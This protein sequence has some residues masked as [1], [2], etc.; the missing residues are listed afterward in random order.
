MEESRLKSQQ[1]EFRL[2]L[3]MA[4]VS[5]PDFEASDTSSCKNRLH[6]ISVRN[7]LTTI[8]LS[9]RRRD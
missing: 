9:G 6:K 1:Q 8:H 7:D 3:L 4:N 2:S 5:V